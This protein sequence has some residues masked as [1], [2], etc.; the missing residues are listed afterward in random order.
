MENNVL[1]END[2]LSQ[3]RSLIGRWLWL[4]LPAIGTLSAQLF[5]KASDDLALSSLEQRLLSGI[6]AALSL[7]WLYLL[8]RVVE[9]K[10][11]QSV[12]ARL[13]PVPS[14]GYSRDPVTGEIACPRCTT[15]AQIVFMRDH[16]T[17][18]FFC[19]VCHKGVLK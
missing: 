1:I 8:I 14:K 16:G 19:W 7:S 12:F 10:K 2:L 13:V 11:K 6:V 9:L 15:E 3:L 4:L 17:D 18:T 5:W